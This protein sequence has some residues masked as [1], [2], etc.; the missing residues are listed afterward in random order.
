MK[1]IEDEAS[2]LA[3]LRAISDR[4]AANSR[5]DKKKSALGSATSNTTSEKPG[6]STTSDTYTR[7]SDAFLVNNPENSNFNQYWY[8]S[9]TIKILSEAIIEILSNI[10]GARVA[11]LSTPS[12]YFA[13][14]EKERRFCQLFEFDKTWS[15]DVGYVH[16]DFNRPESIDD[17]LQKSFDMVVIDPPF[18]TKDVWEK[19]AL[20]A[21]LLLKEDPF[22]DFGKKGVVLGTTVSE[23]ASLMKDLF[24]AEPIVF[25]P[26]IP[27]LV[28]QY[29]VYINCPKD[30]KTL[31]KAN[32]EI[33]ND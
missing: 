17:T 30:C 20:T 12:L 25:K 13:L 2:I 11:F 5:F 19:Y 23:N 14:P 16:Y 29:N 22:A 9:E 15:N 8:S 26:V 18:I 21:K 6:E 24:G 28:Y 32:P 4:G 10:G 1:P 27:H 33:R 7:T 3:E 31:K